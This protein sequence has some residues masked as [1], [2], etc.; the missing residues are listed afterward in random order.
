MSPICVHSSGAVSHVALE[1]VMV[2]NRCQGEDRWVGANGYPQYHV[3]PCGAPCQESGGVHWQA[4]YPSVRCVWLL[5]APVITC[6]LPPVCTEPW[7]CSQSAP[8]FSCPHQSGRLQSPSRSPC[9]K[10]QSQGSSASPVWTQGPNTLRPSKLEGLQTAPEGGYRVAL[11]TQ[12]EKTF[13]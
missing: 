3:S 6:F 7:P 2:E 13:F 9:M 1:A 4:R 11:Q 10:A 5:P 8:R 12:A